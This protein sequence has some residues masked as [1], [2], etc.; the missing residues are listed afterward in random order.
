MAPAPMGQR[1]QSSARWPP[2]P[3]HARHAVPCLARNSWG[4]KRQGSIRSVTVAPQPHTFN[5]VR[6][7]SHRE[8]CPCF[9][10]RAVGRGVVMVR[11]CAILVQGTASDHQQHRSSACARCGAPRIH[12]RRRGAPAL[13]DSPRAAAVR[14]G[15]ASH[16]VGRRRADGDRWDWGWRHWSGS[17]VHAHAREGEYKGRAQR[18]GKRD[19][20]TMRI[21]LRPFQL[22]P[23][24]VL[25]RATSA[26]RG[27][28]VS[29]LTSTSIAMHAC[30]RAH[31]HWQHTGPK[32]SCLPLPL[33]APQLRGVAPRYRTGFPTPR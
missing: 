27:A 12:D 25:A 18:D 2:S 9:G 23:L 11:P 3:E 8:S 24:H 16:H 5:T 20:A 31:C 1:R 29:L 19:G 21:A 28:F 17:V 7:T 10:N 6:W 22:A 26:R 32:A 14:R 30:S 15:A 33:P 4:S 13:R